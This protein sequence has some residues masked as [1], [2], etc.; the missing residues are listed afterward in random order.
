MAK[1]TYTAIT[2]LDG[3]INDE[4][5]NFEW[6]APDE[7]EHAFANDLDR[8]IGTHLYGRRMYEVM[9]Y[10]E[11]PPA[12]SSPVALDYAGVWQAADKVVYSTTLETVTTARTRIERTFEPEAVRQMKAGADRDLSIGG[13]GL[14]A[15]AIAN[16]LV[17]ELHLLVHPVIVGGG[18]RALPHDVRVELALL[19][20]RRFASGVVYLRYRVAT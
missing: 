9:R 3:C 15:Q 7:E 12:D 13:S 8:A 6:A 5:G 11:A 2:S 14:A 20:E 17:D 16:G 18:T 1:L 4:A 19:D 10:W